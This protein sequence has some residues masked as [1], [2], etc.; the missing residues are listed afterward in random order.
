MRPHRRRKGNICSGGVHFKKTLRA[1]ET[2]NSKP[3]LSFVLWHF[4]YLHWRLIKSVPLCMYER[5]CL[6]MWMYVF[7][8]IWLVNHTGHASFDDMWRWGGSRDPGNARTNAWGGHAS[9]KESNIHTWQ[10]E[11]PTQVLLNKTFLQVQACLMHY[12]Y[13]SHIHTTVSLTSN[14][15]FQ[16][17][18]SI[19]L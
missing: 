15:S 6:Y 12:L 5:V 3:E 17:C 9:I 19:A 7:V 2:I 13:W 8:P 1:S 16:A 11:E 4:C 18:L 10:M 14:S